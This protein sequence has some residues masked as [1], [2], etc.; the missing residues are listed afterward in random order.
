LIRTVDVDNQTL[1]RAVAA[2]SQARALVQQTRAQLFPTVTG[3]PS[4]SHSGRGDSEQMSLRLQGSASWEL[5]LFGGT[6]RT[7]ES[8]A[9]LAQS[10]AAPIALTRLSIQAEIAADYLTVRYADSLQKVLDENVENF[11]RTLAITENQYAA[12]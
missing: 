12:G 10:D 3:A 9:A 6:R 7:I 4:I 5:D 8:E 1:R 2:Y 11:K